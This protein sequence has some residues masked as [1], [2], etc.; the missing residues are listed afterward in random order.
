MRALSLDPDDYVVLN[1]YGV[2]L[3]NKKNRP[4]DAF[5]FFRQAMLRNPNDPK[6]ENNL[7]LAVKSKHKFVSLFS[8]NS[9]YLRRHR[10]LKITIL[11][12]PMGLIQA[13]LLVSLIASN[14]VLMLLTLCLFPLVTAYLALVNPTFNVLVKRGWLK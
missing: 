13:G 14:W 3:L 11:I 4:A 1:N 9:F 7:L 12:V 5:E 10:F 8:L 2:H 6:F